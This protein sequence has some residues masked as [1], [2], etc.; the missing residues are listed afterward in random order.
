MLQ[1]L[2]ES[3]TTLLLHQFEN[4]YRSENDKEK[5]LQLKIAEQERVT[6]ELLSKKADYDKWTDQ[7]K[8]IVSTKEAFIATLH[9]NEELLEKEIAQLKEQVY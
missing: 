8:A 5:E 7:I 3:Y 2:V 1:L 9:K 6:Q 4:F